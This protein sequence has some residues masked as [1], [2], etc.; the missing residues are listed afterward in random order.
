[1]S[2][3]HG[4]FP[5]T[6][7][8]FPRVDALIAQVCAEAAFGREDCLRLTLVVEELFTNT[9]THGLRDGGTIELVLDALP[10]RIAVI[11]EDTGPEFDPFAV[12]EPS[13]AAAGVED[14]PVGGLGLVLVGRLG[15][16]VEYS[17]A[18]GRNRISL[19][20]HTAR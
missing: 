12:R 1:M 17:H 9:V 8:A 20:M 15:R 6:M 13:E 19:V 10:G 2:R 5:A 18:D 11:Y 7:D 14:R 3:H 4:A 16:N